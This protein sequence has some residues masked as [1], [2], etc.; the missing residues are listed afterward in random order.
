[1]S[2]Y[3]PRIDLD[4]ISAID[5]HVH[6]ESDEHGHLSLDQELMDA[7]AAYFKSSENRTPTVADLASRY[8]GAGMAAVAEVASVSEVEEKPSALVS[9]AVSAEVV[10]A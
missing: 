8:R 1:M 7:S 5:V 6:V 10:G 4:A 3:V 9:N 2:P